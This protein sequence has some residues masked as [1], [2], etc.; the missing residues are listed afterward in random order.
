MIFRR[1]F[2]CI[3]SKH[4][5]HFGAFLFY[6]SLLCTCKNGTS[7][8]EAL[9]KTLKC[10]NYTQLKNN[11]DFFSLNCLRL[12]SIEQTKTSV[13]FL[14]I[15]LLFFMNIKNQ[16]I[17][18]M[19]DIHLESKIIRTD[20]YEILRKEIWYFHSKFKV[21]NWNFQNINCFIRS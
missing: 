19:I 1:L 15:I 11:S 10:Q 21:R 18:C 2:S 14:K 17:K 8:L 13:L 3:F 20:L 16:W 4:N 7:T 5:D 12:K 9:E 6:F